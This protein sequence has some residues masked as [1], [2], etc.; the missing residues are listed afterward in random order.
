MPGA[1]PP[2][3][4]PSKKAKKVKAPKAPKEGKED[5]LP[6]EGGKGVKIFGLVSMFLAIAGIV[7]AGVL[8]ALNLFFSDYTKNYKDAAKNGIQTETSVNT[9]DS[10]ADQDSS[11]DEPDDSDSSDEN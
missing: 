9:D 1:I 4:M 10:G 2:A 6:G 11:E 7:T 3:G 8:L 5:S